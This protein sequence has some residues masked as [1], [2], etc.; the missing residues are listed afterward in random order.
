[1]EC[2]LSGREC[3]LCGVTDWL[4]VH[5]I[6]FRSQGGDDV[7]ANL[8]LL[9]Q[10]CHDALHAYDSQTWNSLFMY[11][12]NHRP[13]TYEYLEEKLGTSADVYFHR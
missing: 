8:C 11:V 9:C 13:D 10:S 2:R 5:H 1:M 3:A 12:L 7:K 6:L 4:Q